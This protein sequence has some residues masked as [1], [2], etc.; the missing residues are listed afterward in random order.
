MV[1]AIV[2]LRTRDGDIR[3]RGDMENR[4]SVWPRQTRPAAGRANLRLQ[5]SAAV[6]IAIAE[7]RIH[8]GDVPDHR[9]AVFDEAAG[10]IVTGTFD[11]KAARSPKFKPLSLQGD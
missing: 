9:L 2:P 5:D 1:S 4:P 3:F 8:G 10:C 11:V 7:R 6:R